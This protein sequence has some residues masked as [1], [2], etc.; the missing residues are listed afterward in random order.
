MY[1]PHVTI[2]SVEVDASLPFEAISWVQLANTVTM[3]VPGDDIPD[4]L[5]E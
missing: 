2:L 4:T 1:L 5:K 3:T